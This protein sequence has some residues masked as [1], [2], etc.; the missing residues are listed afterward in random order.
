MR[1]ARAALA[2]LVVFGVAAAFVAV[3][4]L[5]PLSAGAFTQQGAW[6]VATPVG[7]EYLCVESARTLRNFPELA[8]QG[9]KEIRE[10]L[11]DNRVAFERL[12]DAN[13]R[14]KRKGTLTQEM[15][16]VR[17][18]SAQR[19]YRNLPA[20]SAA[21]GQRWVDTMGFSATYYKSCFDHV[22]QLPN[23]IMPDHFMR[24]H[25]DVGPSG[26]RA[27]HREG[28]RR[29]RRYFMDA[30]RARRDLVPITDASASQGHFLVL[31]DYFL[32]GRA[33]HLLQ[34]SFSPE[35]TIRTGRG[36]RQIR[37][38]K[39]Y[40]CLLNTFQHSHDKP[41][42]ENRKTNGDVIWAT[43]RFSGWSSRN[44]TIWAKAALAASQDLWI[45]Y[46]SARRRPSSARR[47][48]DK[49]I[50]KWMTL[51]AKPARPPGEGYRRKHCPKGWRSTMS[52]LIREKAV[53]VPRRTKCLQRY[54]GY[55]ILHQ[56]KP[57]YYWEA[58]KK[59]VN[60][61]VEELFWGKG[62]RGFAVYLMTNVS[63]G[64]IWVGSERALRRKKTCHFQGGGLCRKGSPMVQYRAL[65]R[66]FKA[67][68]LAALEYCRNRTTYPKA[69]PLTRGKKATVYGRSYWVTD[70]P[71]HYCPRKPAPVISARDQKYAVILMTNVSGGSVVVRQIHKIKKTKTCHFQGGG[72]CSRT[73]P[74]VKYQIL[75]RLYDGYADAVK[76][77]CRNRTTKP[78][79]IRLTRGRKA[80]VYGRDV[81][82][83]NAPSCPK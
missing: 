31:R 12:K 81:W 44:L 16:L 13:S 7:H 23:A 45:A 6:G 9:Y 74:K 37:E 1:G 35:H 67:F 20:L 5:A 2:A 52:L 19:S 64:S 21:L 50:N 60:R 61:K 39:H 83:S 24:R 29:L 14:L 71:N 48:I 68:K 47:Q 49:V 69:V 26:R 76:D 57:P 17:S 79:S 32:L 53:L 27:A 51:T 15:G 58:K 62:T 33:F 54:T 77:Y 43:G 75:S 72:L 55:S 82:V 46:L 41:L 56:S 36:L 10:I 80:K 78:R 42:I 59:R 25:G 3:S 63:G 8:S 11:R 34:D 22:A 4:L 30:V 28:V 73:S 40:G 65:S 18:Y 66:S 70:A 38:I